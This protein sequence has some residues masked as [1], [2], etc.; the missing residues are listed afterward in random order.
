M[1]VKIINPKHEYIAGTLVSVYHLYRVLESQGVDVSL[2]QFSFSPKAKTGKSEFLDKLGVPYSCQSQADFVAQLEP[3]DIVIANDLSAETGFVGNDEGNMKYLRFLNHVADVIDS[4]LLIINHTPFGRQM[5]Y[6]ET[7]VKKCLTNVDIKI[8]CYRRSHIEQIDC[9]HQQLGYEFPYDTWVL[10]YFYHLGIIPDP[11][12]P[13]LFSNEVEKDIDVLYL[14]RLSSNKPNSLLPDLESLRSQGF[15]V[16][17]VDTNNPVHLSEAFELY[18]RSKI[19]VSGYF[20]QMKTIPEVDMV[21]NKLDWSA[22]DSM[23]LKC[24]FV[25]S[26]LF[27]QELAQFDDTEFILPYDHKNPTGRDT[28]RLLSEIKSYLL[29]WEDYSLARGLLYQRMYKFLQLKNSELPNE[30]YDLAFK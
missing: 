26:D 2:H 8:L 16:H 11:D 18:K 1:R 30:L 6:I 22:L 21:G 20:H 23:L 3:G 17:V 19:S 14:T 29:N 5:Q 25:T 13:E 12:Q 4:S 27:S 7:V 24:K 10:P 9:L 28:A 15:K